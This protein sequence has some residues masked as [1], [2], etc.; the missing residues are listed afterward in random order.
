MQVVND[1]D[2]GGARDVKDANGNVVGTEKR[3][4]LVKSVIAQVGE[5]TSD[6]GTGQVEMGAT[7][8]KG[9]VASYFVK[10]ADRHGDQH[11]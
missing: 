6:P 11:Q 1:P 2:T 3:N 8:N 7:P 5:G 10:F 9:R 4:F